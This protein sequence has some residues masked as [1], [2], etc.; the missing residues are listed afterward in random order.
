MH[1]IVCNLYF[2]LRDKNS[3]EILEHQDSV[4]LQV[5]YSLYIPTPYLI[6]GG[7]PLFIHLLGVHPNV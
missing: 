3:G 1:L 2:V 4:Q 6:P 7:A 5:L